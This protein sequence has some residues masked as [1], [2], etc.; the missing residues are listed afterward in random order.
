MGEEEDLTTTAS[1]SSLSLSFSF[2][3]NCGGRNGL[4]EALAVLFCDAVAFVVVGFA[5]VA[6]DVAVAVA[7]VLIPTEE[8]NG[9]GSDDAFG[10]AAALLPPPPRASP[11]SVRL[12]RGF[13]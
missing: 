7:A 12:D 1:L 13:F 10:R 11:G 8:A 6:V 4:E 5:V 2:Y 9:A 3:L